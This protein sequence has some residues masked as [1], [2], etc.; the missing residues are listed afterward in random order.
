MVNKTALSILI[1]IV[2]TIIIIS[3][4]NVGTSLIVEE[5]TYED[6]CPQAIPLDKQ[7]EMNQSTCEEMGGTWQERYC[8]LTEE[9]RG[10]LEQDRE[11]YNQI[12]FYIFAIIGFALLLTGLFAKENMIQITGLTSGAILVLEGVVFNL[13]NKWIVFIVLLAMFVIFG[14][15]GWKVIKKSV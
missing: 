14:Y 6:Y 15:L 3:L 2:L 9:C 7:S 5:P 12:R 10:E 13:Q 4:V 1:S 11:H 8:D